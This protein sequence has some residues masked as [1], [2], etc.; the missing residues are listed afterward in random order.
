VNDSAGHAPAPA[1]PVDVTPESRRGS[2]VGTFSSVYLIGNAVGSMA[3]GYVA[4][5]LGYRAMW[6]TLTL[7][8]TLGFLSSLRLR[9][10]APRTAPA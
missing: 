8:L 3:F 4:H 2:A 5:G 10:G 6:V 1:T 9:V 7:V